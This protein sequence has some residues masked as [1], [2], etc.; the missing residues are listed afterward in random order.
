MSIEKATELGVRAIIPILTDNC[1]LNKSVVE[2]KID[3]WNRIMLEASKQCERASVPICEIPSSIDKL[4]ASNR[5]DKVIAFCER[6]AT[7]TLREYFNET[8]IKYDENVAIIIGPEGGFSEKEFEFF[9]KNAIPML[10]LGDLILRAETAVTV[11]LGNVVY[12]FSNN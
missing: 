1:A 9:E 5:F 8:P 4:L 7:K 11:A 2:K 10:T 6:K 12:E 3:R